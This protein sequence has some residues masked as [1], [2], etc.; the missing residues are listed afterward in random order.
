MDFKDVIKAALTEYMEDLE[1]ALDGATAQERRFQ[2]TR[3]A[4]HIDYIVWHMARVEDGIINRRICEDLQIWEHGGWYSRL[5]LP[6]EG[7]GEG[8]STEQVATLPVFSF[9]DLM[10]YYRA[11]RQNSFRVIDSLTH[12]DL[13]RIPDP[14]RPRWN[15]ASILAHLVVEEA[16]HV[17]QVAYIRGLHHGI[18]G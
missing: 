6:R 4:N 16:Q 11:V 2:P 1:A 18:D 15:I 9:D 17:G 8:F 10:E 12:D 13:S 3:T 5:S 14:D 7:N